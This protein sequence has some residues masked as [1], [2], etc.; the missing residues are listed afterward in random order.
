MIRKV[1]VLLLMFAAM[2]AV[3]SIASQAQSQPLLTRQTRDAVVNGEVQMVGHL[4]AAQILHF[5]IVLALR[6]AP[7]L[8]NFLQDVYDP[9]SSSYRHFVTVK[10]FTERFGPSQEDYDALIQFAKVNGFKIT[11]GSRD[12]M[13]VRFTAPVGTIEKAFHVTMNLYQHPT[14]NRTFYSPDREPTVDLPFQLWHISGLDNY[15]IPRPAVVHRPASLAKSEAGSGGSCPGGSFCG[16]DM[17]AA[18]YGNGSL[19]GTGQSVGLFEC[20]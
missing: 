5:D 1:S 3:F 20:F 6:H 7:E 8:Q 17:R 16:S 13:D 12:A 9:S 4:P 14:E 10:E 19:N 18:Y 2:L 11:G 15:T